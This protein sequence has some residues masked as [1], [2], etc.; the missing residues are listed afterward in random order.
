MD[1]TITLKGDTLCIV[2]PQGRLV[3]IPDN[4]KGLLVIKRILMARAIALEYEKPTGLGTASAP[5]Q[6]MVDEW[7][8]REDK[9]RLDPITE[10]GEF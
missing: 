7:I 2:L 10:A 1:L 5:I 9:M 6:D 3:A 8:A 4:E